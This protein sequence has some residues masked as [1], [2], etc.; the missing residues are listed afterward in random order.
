MM[1]TEVGS[2]AENASPRPADRVC[3]QHTPMLAH[4]SSPA[5]GATAMRP[6]ARTLLAAALVLLPAA[7][8]ADALPAVGDVDGQPLAANAD[9]LA[10]ALEFLGAPLPAEAAKALD[11]AVQARDA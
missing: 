6:A 1:L 4:R 2:P 10:K 8:R 11:A 9:R 5:E 3:C 7:S